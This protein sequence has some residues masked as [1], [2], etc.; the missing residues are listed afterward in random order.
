MVQRCPVN[1]S[2]NTKHI[3]I[4]WS[5]DY[6]FCDDCKQE[7]SVLKEQ[8]KGLAKKGEFLNSQNRH[9]FSLNLFNS[10]LLSWNY[11]VTGK[12][13]SGKTSL[14]KSILSE[15]LTKSTKHF[16]FIFDENGAY[17]QFVKHNNGLII[18]GTDQSFQQ[19]QNFV[20]KIENQNL[21]S[22]NFS[23]SSDIK[24]CERFLN[25]LS[26]L[27]MSL[28]QDTKKTVVYD[29][30]PSLVN[31][32]CFDLINALLINTIDDNICNILVTNK[33]NQRHILGCLSLLDAFAFCGDE[34]N[35]FDELYRNYDLKG[36]ILG[37]LRKCGFDLDPLTAEVR[38]L[39]FLLYTD[40]KNNG[41]RY[42]QLIHRFP[43]GN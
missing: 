33:P 21:V 40:Y 10:R 20:K 16:I 4:S 13:G 7:I 32:K 3:F 14:V 38:H 30:E 25:L 6:D 42:D 31:E 26:S 15:E 29:F 34:K 17:D 2:H 8:K 35:V 27:L 5:L 23:F 37:K 28:P 24:N 19:I 12:R 43:K 9:K 1:A 22:V 36:N 41:F 11:L 18:D 39:E